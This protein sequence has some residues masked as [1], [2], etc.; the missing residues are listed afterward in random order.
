[1]LKEAKAAPVAAPVA[2]QAPAPQPPQYTEAQIN[3]LFQESPARAMAFL[4]MR[5]KEEAE[6]NVHARYSSHFNSSAN[7]AEASARTKHAD[8]FN[9]YGNEVAAEMNK[10]DVSLRANP[11]VWDQAVEMVKGRHLD[12]IVEK[13]IAARETAAREAAQAKEATLVG[14]AAATVRNGSARTQAPVGAPATQTYGLTAAQLRAAEV[15]GMSPE[16]YAKTLKAMR[17]GR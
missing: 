1:M 6:A 12:A 16:D 5:A 13:R 2:P 15:G 7:M 14:S 3:E 8:V 9:D 17:G 4:A 10:L 11:Q